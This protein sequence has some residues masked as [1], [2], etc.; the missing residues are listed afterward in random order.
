[1]RARLFARAM[2]AAASPLG[3]APC[4][5]DDAPQARAVAAELMGHDVVSV[6]TILAVQTLQPAS[7]LVLHEDGVVRGLVATLLLKPAAEPI[8]AA[9]DFNG[10]QPQAHLLAEP[11]DAVGF[12]YVW[13]IAGA[14]RSA[15]S[16]VVELCRRLRYGALASLTAYATAATPAGRRVGVTQL[17]FQPVRHADD[18]LLVSAPAEQRRA[19]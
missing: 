16:A 1:M 17:G 13:G 11:D 5:P 7:S 3:F 18:D 10:L 19:A 9:G 6:P 12:Y 2:L 15:S 14:S 4:R 8:L